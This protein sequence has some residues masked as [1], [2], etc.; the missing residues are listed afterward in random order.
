V[1]DSEWAVIANVHAEAFGGM[2]RIAIM[3]ARRYLVNFRAKVA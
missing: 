2:R 1:A 3:T